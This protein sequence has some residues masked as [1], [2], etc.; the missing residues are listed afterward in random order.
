MT[1]VASEMAFWLFLSLLPLAAVAGLV[2]ARFAMKDAGTTSSL[3][4]SLPPSTRELLTTELGKVSAWNGGAVAPIA[5]LTF[6][7]LAS[8]GVQAVF[9]GLEL[10]AQAKARPWWKKRLLSIGACVALSVGVAVIA[11][12]G[13]GMSWVEKLVGR[14]PM[15]DAIPPVV[16][17]VVRLVIGFALAVA[18]VAGIYALGLPK[19]AR[20]RMPL[21]PG[22]IAAVVAQ[23]ILGFGYGFYVR[24]AGDGGA[25]QAGLAVIGIT[26]MALYLLSIALLLGV[27]INLMLGARRLLEASVHPAISPP[28]V[29]T[30]DMVFCE[31]K[32]DH[33]LENEGPRG[34]LRPSFSG[35]A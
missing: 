17:L 29:V 19:D 30:K 16:G 25:Y 13:T 31:R 2:L 1:G 21:I 35:V 11:F 15:V 22:A 3:L 10:V 14:I 26:L 7:W 28:P 33:L 8:S 4:S 27:E 34:S 20:K 9:D 32:V 6:V 5:A 24:R 12:L 18:L 23:T